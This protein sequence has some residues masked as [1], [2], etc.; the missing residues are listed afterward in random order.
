MILYM[1]HYIPHMISIDRSYTY[2]S[3]VD[4]QATGDLN[5]VGLD[6]TALIVHNC[7]CTCK[8]S[9]LNPADCSSGPL[10]MSRE[11]NTSVVPPLLNCLLSWH[12]LYAL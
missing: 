11:G 2:A 6:I 5:V 10:C 3:A 9:T 12:L 8:S 4:R 1:F 7:S